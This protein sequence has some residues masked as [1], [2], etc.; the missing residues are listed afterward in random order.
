M[1][2][3]PKIKRIIRKFCGASGALMYPTQKHRPAVWEMILGTVNA[4]N[5]QGEI[6]YFD[7]N[8]KEALAFAGVSKKTDVRIA[9]T[10][11]RYYFPYDSVTKN[12]CKGQI[13]L[14]VEKK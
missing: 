2:E 9:K 8:Y 14:W 4:M 3:K 1:P 5:D 11:E 6:K 10:R 13:V 7:Y 12:I